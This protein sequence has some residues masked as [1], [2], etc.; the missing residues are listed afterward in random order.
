MLP[1]RPTGQQWWRN[2][3]RGP[4]L[5]S[6]FGAV[7]FAALPIVSVTGL[8]SWVAYGSQLGQ[9]IPTDPGWLHLPVPPLDPGLLLP[10]DTPTQ[11]TRPS[12]SKAAQRG[13][14]V[15][16]TQAA[17]GRRDRAARSPAGHARHL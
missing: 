12:P 9:A 15:R 2:P 13:A 3:L 5:T 7:L 8:L 17:A 11:A 10:A 16:G 1:M 6:M 14:P 4:W